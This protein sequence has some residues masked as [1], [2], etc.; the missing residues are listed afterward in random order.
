MT[1]N[2]DVAAVRAHYQPRLTGRVVFTYDNHHTTDGAGS[3]LQRIYGIFAVARLLGAAYLHTPL[4][5]VDYQGVLALERH[6]LDPHFHRAFNAVCR[7]PSDTLPAG[8]LEERTISYLSLERLDALLGPPND[9]SPMRPLLLH[10]GMPFG[11]SDRFPDSLVVCQDVSPFQW[12]EQS[13]RP[14]RVAVHVRRGELFVVESQRM[15]P[16]SYYVAAARQVARALEARGIAYGIELHTEIPTAEFAVKP[17][18]PGLMSRAVNS[19]ISPAMSHL[20]DFEVLPHLVRCI[21][22]PTLDCLRKLATADV[23]L[24]SRSSFSYLAAILNRRGIV[25]CNPFWHGTL[26]SWLQVNDQ[27]AFDSTRFVEALDK[28]LSRGGVYPP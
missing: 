18:Y 9:R 17:G 23:L 12:P 13:G 16:N 19:V 24:M 6:E 15:L 20:T 8:D 27:G 5:R 3:Q 26:S 14:L 2:D 21:N 28:F 11:I 1:T 7:L 25:L 10:I 22:D 4:L